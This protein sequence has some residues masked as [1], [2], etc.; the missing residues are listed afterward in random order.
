MQ[1]GHRKEIRKLTL[2]ALALRRI[3]SDEGLTLEASAF[4][5]LYGGQFTLS[6]L[7]W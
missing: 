2:W 7:S 3:R 1:I 6:T 5:S 4:E